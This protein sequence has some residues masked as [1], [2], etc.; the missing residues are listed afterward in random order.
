[1]A[2]D[3]DDPRARYA[4]AEREHAEAKR[5]VARAKL[6]EVRAE[7]ESVHMKTQAAM[8]RAKRQRDC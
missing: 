8:E 6:E 7:W 5:A 4:K 3:D 1:M 2:Q